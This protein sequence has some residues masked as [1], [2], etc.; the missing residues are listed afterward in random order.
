MEAA[1]M[2]VTLNEE[3]LM[4]FVGKAIGDFGTRSTARS[5]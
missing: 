4:A 2:T 1:S 5:W 3:R